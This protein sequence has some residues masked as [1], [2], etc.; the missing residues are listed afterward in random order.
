MPLLFIPVVQLAVTVHGPPETNV[1]G[2]PIHVAVSS[3]CFQKKDKDSSVGRTTS[4]RVNVAL[5]ADV[6][7][8]DP[9]RQATSVA[10]GTLR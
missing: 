5:F 6:L 9:G 4:D 1:S 8:G 2:T 10:T 3:A 7:R